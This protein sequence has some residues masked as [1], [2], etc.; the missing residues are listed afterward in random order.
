MQKSIDNSD[1]KT[2]TD[3]IDENLSRNINSEERGTFSESVNRGLVKATEK[4]S[5][6]T[7]SKSD[8]SQSNEARS[9]DDSTVHG[10]SDESRHDIA[11]SRTDDSRIVDMKSKVLNKEKNRAKIRPMKCTKIRP[12]RSTQTPLL[13]NIALTQRTVTRISLTASTGQIPW[14]LTKVKLNHPITTSK[15]KPTLRPAKT[16]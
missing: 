16:R 6:N 2:I 1:I 4:S 10:W 15:V 12:N 7:K 13:S 14:L 3:T 5:A 9:W 8:E 11:I